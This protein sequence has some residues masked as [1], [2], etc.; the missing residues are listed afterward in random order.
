MLAFLVGLF[1]FYQAMSLSLT[2]RQPLV[3]ILRQ[4]GVSG[5]QLTV[6]LG[7]ELLILIFFSWLCGNLLG[8]VLA[9]Q[10]IPAVS[11]SLRDLYDANVELVV[12]WSW[13]QQYTA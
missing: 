4:T 10:L 3:G 12:S 11:G 6:A 7:I 9:N 2:Q 5:S 13:C 1:I 8:I